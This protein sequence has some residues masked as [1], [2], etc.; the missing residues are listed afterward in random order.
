MTI[1]ILMHLIKAVSF[2]HP[3]WPKCG[4]FETYHLLGDALIVLVA[5]G[6]AS[7]VENG[8]GN[9]DYN[10]ARASIVSGQI[11]IGTASDEDVEAY[12][13]A[14]SYTLA[15]VSSFLGLSH[16]LTRKAEVQS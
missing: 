13:L 12:A 10:T 4:M 7:P 11:C 9:F 14:L 2:L 16:S 3:Y 6:F 1:R 8:N 5:G 15:A